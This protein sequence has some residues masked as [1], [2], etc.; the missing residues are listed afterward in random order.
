[1]SDKKKSLMA[2]VVTNSNGN[3]TLPTTTPFMDRLSHAVIK[4]TSKNL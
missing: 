2:R 1:V 3:T 4:E